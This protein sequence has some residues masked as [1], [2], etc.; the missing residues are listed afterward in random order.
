[1]YYIYVIWCKKNDEY[2]L[3]YSKDPHNRLQQH[4]SGIDASTQGRTWD[5]VYI[6][7]YTN[8]KYAQHREA[9]LKRN[10]RMRTFLMN[11]VK[12]SIKDLE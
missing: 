5:L 10:G 1:M 6:E 8:K 4:N 9:M 3:G 2:Y 11:R 7:G 12:E